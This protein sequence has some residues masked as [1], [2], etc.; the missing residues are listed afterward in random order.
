MWGRYQKGLKRLKGRDRRLIVGRAELGYNLEQ[1][2]AIERLPSPDAARM[3]LKRAVIRLSEF[4]SLASG[5]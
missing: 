4:M 1:L 3:A 5:R 2:A